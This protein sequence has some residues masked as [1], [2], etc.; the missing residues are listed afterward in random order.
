L[1]LS[2]YSG[3]NFEAPKKHDIFKAPT[4]CLE[5]KRNACPDIDCGG[6]SRYISLSVREV[7]LI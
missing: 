6:N 4:I 2:P 3:G 7:R 1:I 5:D